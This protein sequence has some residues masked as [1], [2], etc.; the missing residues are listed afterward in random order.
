MDG[1]MIIVTYHAVG[2]R[3][4]PEC[5]TAAQLRS[6]LDGLRDAGFSFVSL[7]RCAGWLEGGIPPA[8]RSVAVTFDD[9]YASVAS[10]AAPI[11]AGRGIPFTVF[12]IAGRIG[13]D[14][15]WPGQWRSIPRMPLMDEVQLRAVVDA[16]GA[17]GCHS[18]THAAL[19]SL[20]AARLRREV[21]D[22][23]HRLED[24]T[25]SAIEHYAYPYGFRGAR[26]IAMVRDHYRAG[27]NAYPAVVRDTD[28]RYDLNRIDC[29]D[30]RVALRLRLVRQPVL[31]PYLG[32]RRTLRAMRRRLEGTGTPRL[33]GACIT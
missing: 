24:L 13:G 14:N 3:N 4:S 8:G 26:E 27:V 16:G 19:P 2:D 11:L 5:V 23:R 6:D 31:Q 7:D 33:S 28:R 18:W 30:L 20:D 17:I 29:H 12:A 32:F 10:L 21:V 22:A 25:G 1:S 9:G 15:Q